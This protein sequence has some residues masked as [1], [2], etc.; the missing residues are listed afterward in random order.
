[1]LC[2]ESE[3]PPSLYAD[4]GKVINEIK[5]STEKNAY[6]NIYRQTSLEWRV[7]KEETLERFWVLQTAKEIDGQEYTVN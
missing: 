6:L 4:A 7:I 1:M 2:S 5:H 3:E